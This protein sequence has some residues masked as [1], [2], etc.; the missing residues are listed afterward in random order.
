[1]KK[2]KV[3]LIVF[4][5][6]LL[7]W[8]VVIV[9]VSK[10]R[11]FEDTP[12]FLTKCNAN[13]K[14]G[15]IPWEG[16]LD[17]NPVSINDLKRLSFENFSEDSLRRR[18]STLKV[19]NLKT[20][21]DI[22]KA[23][24]KV[25]EEIDASKPYT[26]QVIYLDLQCLKDMLGETSLKQLQKLLGPL[27]KF[28]LFKLWINTEGYATPLHADNVRNVVLQLSGSKR[29]VIASRK[30]EKQCYFSHKNKKNNSYYKVKNPYKPDLNAYP[31]FKKVKLLYFD[32]HSGD[33]LYIPKNYIH[34]VH[35][36]D[37]SIMLSF[38]FK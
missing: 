4:G 2:L 13:C 23:N 34:F 26:T 6:I 22:Q 35:S 10:K 11:S 25:L 27:T 15:S 8:I 32:M 33:L 21:D 38:I 3:C 12:S 1:M 14:F 7:I 28:H 18:K 30:Y 17:L 19:M 24:K 20:I 37:C 5:L 16:H 29:W 9:C 36:N 31:Q